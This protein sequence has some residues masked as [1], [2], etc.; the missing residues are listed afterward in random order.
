M[1]CVI[2]YYRQGEFNAIP[3]LS[4]WGDTAER[5][6]CHLEALGVKQFLRQREILKIRIIT[7]HCIIFIIL[8]REGSCDVEFKMGYALFE[9]REMVSSSGSK[10]R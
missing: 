7:A 6:Y 4:V 1:S 10:T 2:S 3:G 5:V 8:Q 9:R